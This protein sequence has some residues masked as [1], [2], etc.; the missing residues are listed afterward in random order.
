MRLT[1]TFK[2]AFITAVM[3]DIPMQDKDKLSKE[4]QEILA[5][6]MPH[7]VHSVY[8]LC[9][10]WLDEQTVFCYDGGG[11]RNNITLRYFWPE[12]NENTLP[13]EAR[14]F[15]IAVKESHQKRTQFH[16]DLK[17]TVSGISTL[18]RLQDVFPELI[19]YMPTEETKTK[20][21]PVCANLM[22]DAVKL[23]WPKGTQPCAT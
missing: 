18:K 22:A 5:A 9:P 8:C 4:L 11:W 10:E 6:H 7:E 19:R 2:N 20:G 17:N 1:K 3:D 23:G 21:L 15:I 16:N 12:Y 14:D 13:Q